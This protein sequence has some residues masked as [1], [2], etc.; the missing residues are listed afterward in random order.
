MSVLADIGPKILVLSA[1]GASGA[2]PTLARIVSRSLANADADVTHIALADY[3]MPLLASGPGGNASVLPDNARKIARHLAMHDGVLL[4]SGEVNASL[5]AAVKNM[6]DWVSLVP[7]AP[8]NGPPVVLAT[9][10]G[11]TGGQ[12]AVGDHLRTVLEAAGV[13]D[14]PGTFVFRTAELEA[15]GEGEGMVSIRIRAVTDML[16]RAIPR[17]L[18]V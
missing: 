6:I 4:I 17:Q 12:T 1:G 13:R 8:W 18:P 10:T 3:P 15:A 2:G 16:L 7:G 9:L 5:P 11:K 14:I